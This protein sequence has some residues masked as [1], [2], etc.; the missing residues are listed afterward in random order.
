M[1]KKRKKI[2]SEA[3][4]FVS[5]LLSQKLNTCF[6]FH[7]LRHTKDVANAVKTISRY[8]KLRQD[9]YFVLLI[10]AWF[11]DTGFVDGKILNHE[12]KSRE[13]AEQ[14]L[15]HKVSRRIIFKVASCIN[16]TRLPQTPHN[17]AERIL[18]DADL[19]HLGTSY[20]DQ[21]T[22]LLKQETELYFNKKI[23][24]KD[25]IKANTDFLSRHKYFTKYA[26]KK[27]QPKKDKWLKQQKQ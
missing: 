16:A 11:H 20:F 15:N 25:W 3:R 22:K 5:D 21:R 18:C 7:D 14:F 13:I 9:D 27:L 6:V 19:F 4:I 23:P 10:S 26:K 17:L 1:T 24:D 8:C 2:L 12:N